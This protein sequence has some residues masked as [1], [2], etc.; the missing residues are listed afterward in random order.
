MLSP[1]TAGENHP[2]FNMTAKPAQKVPTH[3]SAKTQ[4]GYK[5]YFKTDWA[6]SSF[7]PL[8]WR[9]SNLT[10]S[11]MELD[12]KQSAICG[13][14]LSIVMCKRISWQDKSVIGIQPLCVCNDV[15]AQTEN[16]HSR[17]T[18][19]PD[20]TNGLLTAMNWSQN[21]LQQLHVSLCHNS[22]WS[23]CFQL[24]SWI[25]RKRSHEMCD[26]TLKNAYQHY[27]TMSLLN[28]KLD[29]W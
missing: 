13:F 17:V 6:L 21:L 5:L 4:T 20:A 27:V 8:P 2:R 9:L 25:R 1:G 26:S 7:L 3:C 19:C 22:A 11:Q 14:N 10:T 18:V 29:A 12:E 23:V 24:C 28:H 16:N 15:E